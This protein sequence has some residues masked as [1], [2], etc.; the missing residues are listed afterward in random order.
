[1]SMNWCRLYL[2]SSCLTL[3]NSSHAWSYHFWLNTKPFLAKHQTIP[4][5]A[6]NHSKSSIKPCFVKHQTVP[7]QA[8]N[9]SLSSR[10]LHNLFTTQ[11]FPCQAV[12]STI[13]YSNRSLH[14]MFVQSHRSKKVIC[15]QCFVFLL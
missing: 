11:T 8:S 3:P 2:C 12:P 1:M 14:K 7:S 5:Q 10:S 13:T 9:H 6:L 15:L 4:S